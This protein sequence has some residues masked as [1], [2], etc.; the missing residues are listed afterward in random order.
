MSR[1]IMEKNDTYMLATIQRNM[2]VPYKNH[3]KDRVSKDINNYKD[4]QD[5]IYLLYQTRDL[6][7]LRH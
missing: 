5:P 3:S 1:M 2:D 6:N 7:S 4:S